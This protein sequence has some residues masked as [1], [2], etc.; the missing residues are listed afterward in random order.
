MD[1]RTRKV[2]NDIIL[3]NSLIC[4]GYAEAEIESLLD[5]PKEVVEGYVKTI[6]E[7]T[8]N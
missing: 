4:K 2:L 8:T 7:L 3:V 6:K 1:A 5:L